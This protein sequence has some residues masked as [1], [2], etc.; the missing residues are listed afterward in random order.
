MKA[1]RGRQW[2]SQRRPWKLQDTGILR[3][4]DFQ[5]GIRIRKLEQDPDLED[6]QPPSSTSHELLL[7]KLLEVSST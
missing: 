4:K 2:P 1:G 5:P 3:K 6:S 7:R